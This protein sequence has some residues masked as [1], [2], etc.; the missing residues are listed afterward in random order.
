MRKWQE[1]AVNAIMNFSI[2]LMAGGILRIALDFTSVVSSV[3]IFFCGAYI[4]FFAIMGAKQ[5]DERI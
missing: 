4:L 5:L 3:I 2:A 1:L